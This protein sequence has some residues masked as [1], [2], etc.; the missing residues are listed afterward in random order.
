MGRLV[1]VSSCRLKVSRLSLGRPS[2]MR[3]GDWAVSKASSRLGVGEGSIGE[4]LYRSSSEGLF[5]SIG[6]AGLCGASRR[7]VAAL[8]TPG[9]GVFAWRFPLGRD[10]CGRGVAGLW[11]LCGGLTLSP[12]YGIAAVLSSGLKLWVWSGSV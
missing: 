6:F 2:V 12:G 3:V 10:R 11:L 1:E 8:S 4:A 5:I 9:D 7:R